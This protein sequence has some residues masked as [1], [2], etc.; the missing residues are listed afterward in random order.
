MSSTQYQHAVSNPSRYSLISAQMW[1]FEQKR[2]EAEEK[3]SFEEFA[4][5]LKVCEDIG[6]IDPN[7]LTKLEAA[8]SYQDNEI[9]AVGN[10]EIHVPQKMFT[11]SFTEFIENLKIYFN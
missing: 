4:P 8:F 2:V 5:R 11:H 9:S 3:V 7:L 1:T 10:Y 6:Y